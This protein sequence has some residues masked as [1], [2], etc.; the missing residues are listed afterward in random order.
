MNT[1]ARKIYPNNYV[2][3]WPFRSLSFTGKERDEETGYGYFGAR[4]MDHEL[5]TMW[6]SVD[7][8]ADKYPSISPYAYC[9]WNPVKLVDPDGRK[10]RFAKG[11]TIAQK[12]QFYDAVKYLDAHNCGGRYGQL[13]RSKIVYTVS[14]ISDYPKGSSFDNKSQTI[15]WCPT[16]G[17]ETD[18]GH[19]LSPATILNHEMTHATHYDDAKN[20]YD[21]NYYHHSQEKAIS[22]YREY[23]NSLNYDNTNPYNS[24]E[25]QSVIAG[26][27]QRTAKL[28]GEIKD[29]EVT[30]KNHK[31]ELI[32]V[33]G[34]TST[35]KI[36]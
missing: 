5:M 8:M 33:D 32:K 19:T 34:P 35:N 9:A 1:P 28:L 20:K 7:P 12:K 22:E 16:A 30:R 23:E 21:Y 13:K 17:L 29:G 14:F 6:L 11:T 36:E 15:N 10:I 2:I 27:E 18:Q 4:Y 31:G 26:V 3:I 24:T 25:E